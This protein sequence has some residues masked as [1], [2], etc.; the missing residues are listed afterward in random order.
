MISRP[1]VAKRFRAAADLAAA[2]LSKLKH[3]S[4]AAAAKAAAAA[5]C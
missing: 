4:D 2:E 5:G 1:M 3:I